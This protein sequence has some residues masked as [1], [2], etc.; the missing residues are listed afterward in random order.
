MLLKL[1]FAYCEK[2]FQCKI[3]C[4]GQP[5]LE[6]SSNIHGFCLAINTPPGSH[7]HALCLI[8]D[9]LKTSVIYILLGRSKT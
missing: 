4:F 8:L 5:F 9:K 6:N 1:Q 7:E 2:T 3:G